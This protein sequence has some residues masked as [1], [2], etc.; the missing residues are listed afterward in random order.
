MKI[1]NIVCVLSLIIA[2]F[3]STSVT[4]QA[5]WSTGYGNVDQAIE[6][7]I[8]A[9]DVD[10]YSTV[11]K[12]EFAD[13]LSKAY[14]GDSTTSNAGIPGADEPASMAYIAIAYETIT[15]QWI[16]N[17][18]FWRYL[19]SGDYVAMVEAINLIVQSLPASA[20]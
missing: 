9:D 3:L 17:A 7:G 14:Y 2:I 6:L 12:G 20:G 16:G 19:S 5:S 15:G 18:P 1:K 8:V 4:A 13:M 11:T 10:L